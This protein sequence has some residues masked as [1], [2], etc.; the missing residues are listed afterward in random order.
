MSIL[1]KL[2]APDASENRVEL[3][4]EVA[5]LF[6]AA[7]KRGISEEQKDDF[8]EI[9][10][11]LLSNLNL[12]ERETMSGR[13]AVSENAPRKL[14]L[15]MAKDE[16]SVA[17]PVLR[18]SPVL[19]DDDLVEISE[20]STIDHRIV[21]SQRK[22]LSE[23]VTDELIKH[24]EMPVMRAVASNPTAEISKVGYGQLAT[25][26]SNDRALANDL[27]T[28]ANLP[29]EVAEAIMPTL[30]AKARK[31]L[32]EMLAGYD[33]S[34]QKVIAKAKD[35]S[36]KNVINRKSKRLQAKAMAK[37]IED[38]KKSLEEVTL[39]LAQEERAH[40]LA[41]VFSEISLL[42]E[43]KTF[44]AITDVNGDLL[45]LICRAFDLPFGVYAAVEKMRRSLLHLPPK[46]TDDRQNKYETVTVQ[47]AQKTM[48]FVNIVIKSS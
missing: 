25:H 24:E 1:D 9:L 44:H 12:D 8:G 43:S 18:L 48:R 20:T 23:R 34:L 47:A 28:R 16:V 3:G 11:Q 29:S 21:L 30:D 45:A 7:E 6:F 19:T 26:S 27:A 15:T 35:T 40:D 38:G 46:G 22:N 36:S 39:L 32:K 42:P 2:S 5:N 41:M 33:G 14:V 31:N 13:M 17:E 10:S 4:R 37:E